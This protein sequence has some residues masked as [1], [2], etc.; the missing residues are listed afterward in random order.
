M[1][2]EFPK[3]VKLAAWERSGGHCECCGQKIIGTPEYHHRVPCAVGG[4]NALDNCQ[5]LAVKCHK[6]RTAQIDVPE[7]AKSHRIFEKRIG[8][9]S[10]P[11]GFRFWRGFD[12]SIRWKS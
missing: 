2:H 11:S 4:S 3:F 12:G 1:R 6:L 7:I 5:V 10:K 8:A 9:R